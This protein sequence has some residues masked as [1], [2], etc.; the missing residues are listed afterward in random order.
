MNDI[1][2][3]IDA[4]YDRDNASDGVS[5]FGA[6]VRQSSLI[7]ECY[8]QDDDDEQARGAWFAVS[9]WETANPP[10]MAPGYVRRHPRV[11]R[12]WLQRQWE[13]PPLL[14]F[15]DLVVPW[16]APLARSRGWQAAARWRDW[17]VASFAGEER[18][19][20]PD[21]EEITQ[22]PYVLTTARLMF[23]LSGVSLPNA[24]IGPAE[25]SESAREVVGT[26]VDAMNAVVTPVVAVLER[27]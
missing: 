23:P 12:A 6:Y 1:A 2:F 13:N 4:E 11:R 19:Y 24:P 10:V 25:A 14:G 7:A 27:S 17:P 8:R 22:H 3:W 20:E 26:L 9:A 18:Y 21:D 15:A 5:R 16:P